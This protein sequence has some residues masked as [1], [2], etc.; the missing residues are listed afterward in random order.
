MFR[1]MKD[2]DGLYFV[3]KDEGSSWNSDYVRCSEYFS[4]RSG[5]EKWMQKNHPE[6]LFVK[7]KLRPVEV[8]HYVRR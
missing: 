1:I 3:E 7:T 4:Y 5:A 6:F 8:A 2:V